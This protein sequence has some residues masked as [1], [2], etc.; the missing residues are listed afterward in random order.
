MERIEER[1]FDIVASTFRCDLASVTR[2]TTAGDVDGWDSLSHAVLLLTIER[3][4]GIKLD[5]TTILDVDNV[6]GLI[7]GVAASIAARQTPAH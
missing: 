4:F 3:H 7:D 1:I 5:L 6:G 2:A